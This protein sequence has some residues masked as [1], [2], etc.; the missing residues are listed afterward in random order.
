[1]HVT[2]SRYDPLYK[3]LVEEL[4]L[5]WDTDAQVKHRRL[6]LVARGLVEKNEK[7]WRFVEGA[8]DE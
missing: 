6:W 4:K 5:G 1:M 3:S 2:V 8:R 7:N